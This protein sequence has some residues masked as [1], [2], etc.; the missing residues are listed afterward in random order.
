[1][2][3]ISFRQPRAR[4]LAEATIAGAVALSA[5]V[6]GPGIFREHPTAT[7]EAAASQ[8]AADAST[9]T[10]APPSAASIDPATAN[11]SPSDANLTHIRLAH[12][13]A[14]Q[15]AV[16]FL[17]ASPDEQATLI[18]FLSLPPLPAPDATPAPQAPAAPQPAAVATPAVASGSVWD[19]VA[20]CEAHNN[21]ATH[22]ASGFSGGL[23]FADATWRSYGGTAFAPSAWQASREQQISVA[24]R[25]LTS[26]G[27]QAWPACSRKLGL[28]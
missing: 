19:R 20:T 23:Q 2:P 24:E 6:A 21:W 12:D 15:M 3:L 26:A 17:N 22:T 28:R 4:H 7:V 1:M 27:W 8:P 18:A 9:T 25:V 14:H 10:V 5:I 11:M 13:P 16:T